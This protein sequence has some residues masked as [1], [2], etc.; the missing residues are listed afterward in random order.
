MEKKLPLYTLPQVWRNWKQTRSSGTGAEARKSKPSRQSCFKL[1]S[2]LYNPVSKSPPQG[3][4]K[5]SWQDGCSLQSTFSSSSHHQW[6]CDLTD[7]AYV[8]PVLVYYLFH[9]LLLRR[10]GCGVQA[11]VLL[12]AA[13]MEMVKAAEDTAA[14]LQ[15]ESFVQKPQEPTGRWRDKETLI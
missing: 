1:L 12:R 3:L 11:L 4:T 9:P 7:R 6:G 5:L 15:L 2:N 14:S 8:H 13:G 10:A